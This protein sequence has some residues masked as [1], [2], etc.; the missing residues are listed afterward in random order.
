MNDVSPQQDDF[1]E[2]LVRAVIIENPP[3]EQGVRT[4]WKEHVGWNRKE[5]VHLRGAGLPE[6]S[7]LNDANSKIRK[8][9]EGGGET[10]GTRFRPN[11]M[12][13][14]WLA[15]IVFVVSIV[16]MFLRISRTKSKT[17]QQ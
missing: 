9:D 8:D 12:I 5:Y 17:R 10:I 4:E 15:L 11:N 6:G 13:F 7:N 16:L 2:S 14:R 1:E 3:E